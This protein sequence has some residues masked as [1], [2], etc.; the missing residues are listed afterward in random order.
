MHLL[1]RHC[2]S[3]SILFTSILFNHPWSKFFSLS[4]QNFH[5]SIRKRHY[6]YI[7]IVWWPVPLVSAYSGMKTY[8]GLHSSSEHRTLFRLRC[9]QVACFCTSANRAPTAVKAKLKA[10]Y[11]CFYFSSLKLFSEFSSYRGYSYFFFWWKSDNYTDKQ[12]TI[13]VE[14]CFLDSFWTG[15]WRKVKFARLGVLP[16]G[17]FWNVAFRSFFQSVVAFKQW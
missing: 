17:L 13:N 11:L 8:N 16:L 5:E 1:T 2:I 12:L 7:D 14:S 9:Q 15:F 10:S 3:Y 4:V 6:P